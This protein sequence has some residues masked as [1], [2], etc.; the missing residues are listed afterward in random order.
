GKQSL[1]M[2]YLSNDL[3]RIVDPEYIFGADGD[4]VDPRL[5]AFTWKQVVERLEQAR[6]LYRAKNVAE[7]EI[8]WAIQNA[9]IVGQCMQWRSGE[10]SRDRSMAE[11]VKWIIY[12]SNGAK[13]VVWSTNGHVAAGGFGDDLMGA[14]LRKLFGQQMIVFGFAFNQGSFQA[15]DQGK[16]V[17]DVTVPAAP[18]GSLD[19]TLAATGIPL[20]ALDLRQAPKNGPVAEWLR[21]AHKSRNVGPTYVD[22]RPDRYMADLIAPE[23]F[24]GILFVEK[25]TAR[26]KR[27]RRR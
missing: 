18:A 21:A 26:H 20:F 27:L 10:A 9:R 25:S 23:C 16:V 17:R 19:A 11:N 3:P 6:E 4:S 14:L 22:D 2:R 24:D 7:R 13:V 12:H 15:Q 8:D 1:Q 5:A